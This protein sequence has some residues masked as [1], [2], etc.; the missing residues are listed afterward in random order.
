MKRC[1]RD[2]RNWPLFIRRI[3]SE[4]VLLLPGKAAIY[5]VPVI[6]QVS[7]IYQASAIYQVY[8]NGRVSAIYQM[9]VIYQTLT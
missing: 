8:A 3:D 5:Q 1:F 7:A 2:C 9:A 6:Y 4:S